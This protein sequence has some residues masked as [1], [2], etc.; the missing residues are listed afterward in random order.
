[1]LF[2]AFEYFFTKNTFCF[3]RTTNP[4]KIL[5]HKV[6]KQPMTCQTKGKIIWCAVPLNRDERKQGAKIKI[7]HLI[8]TLYSVDRVHRKRC[9]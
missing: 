1:M 4:I 6:I 8:K 9:K 5:S 3:E 7:L 2:L